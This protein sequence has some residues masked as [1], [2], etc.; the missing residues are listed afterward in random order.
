MI[1]RSISPAF[2]SPSLMISHEFETAVPFPHSIF[3]TPKHGLIRLPDSARNQGP[4][5]SHVLSLGRAGLLPLLLAASGIPLEVSDSDFKM[6]I[7]MLVPK[8]RPSLSYLI[9]R[10]NCGG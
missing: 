10:E 3:L 9:G 8:T 6:S 1:L 4:A 2:P 5:S 7:S